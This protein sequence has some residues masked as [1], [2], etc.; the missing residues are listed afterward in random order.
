MEVVG[1]HSADHPKLAG[2]GD[3]DDVRSKVFYG[4]GDGCEMAKEAGVEAEILIER[5]CK[6]ATRQ[7]ECSDVA[8]RKKAR[9][10]LCR[11]AACANAEKGEIAPSGEGLEVAAGVCHA[12]DFVEG[13]RKVGYAHQAAK[14]RLDRV[15]LAMGRTAGKQFGKTC[16]RAE[17]GDD[18]RIYF[19][20]YCI[21]CAAYMGAASY[22][23]IRFS[24]GLTQPLRPAQIST[25]EI[26]ST[27]CGGFR[28]LHG[29]P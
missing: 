26:R 14:R 24:D 20:G 16:F 18:E 6:E 13:V 23:C 22:S 27:P 1:K 15:R 7:L 11:P 5:K 8:F 25:G 2:A 21:P 4:A 17:R 12:I 9:L 3:V 28:R 29:C 10:S 19:Y